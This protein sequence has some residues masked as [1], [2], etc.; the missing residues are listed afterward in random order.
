M[1][2]INGGYSP[3]VLFSL[4]HLLWE[5]RLPQSEPRAARSPGKN[6]CAFP[7]FV[8]PCPLLIGS[9]PS[10][11]PLCLCFC[12]SLSFCCLFHSPV[13]AFLPFSPVLPFSDF[14]HLYA[15]IRFFSRTFPFQP[16]TMQYVL[17]CCV[18]ITG[19]S[20]KMR[21]TQAPVL[22]GSHLVWKTDAHSSLPQPG[23]P[24]HSLWGLLP[25]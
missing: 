15:I 9:P 6:I 19:R 21:R 11:S 1:R 25:S 10:L 22:R 2:I 23:P 24:T 14:T 20:R 8:S 4:L 16:T 7:C 3:C 13:K 18:Q 17:S 12:P 5:S